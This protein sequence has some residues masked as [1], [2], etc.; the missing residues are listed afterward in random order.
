MFFNSSLPVYPTQTSLPAPSTQKSG[1]LTQVVYEAECIIK[2]MEPLDARS[3]QAL[4]NNFDKS[5]A[6]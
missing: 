2:S 3:N 1:F 6:Y 5:R 4:R